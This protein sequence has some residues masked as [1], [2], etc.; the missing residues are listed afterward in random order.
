LEAIPH[1]IRTLYGK[2]IGVGKRARKRKLYYSQSELP[3]NDAKN[4]KSIN[5]IGFESS[6]YIAL[7]KWLRGITSK[8]CVGCSGDHGT[9]GAG[10][11]GGG[12]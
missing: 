11:K 10:S 5:M 8:I 12:G 2:Q 6:L 4:E 7:A 9:H 3:Q 1:L